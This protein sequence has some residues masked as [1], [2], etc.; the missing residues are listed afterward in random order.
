MS[1]SIRVTKGAAASLVLLLIVA[2][3]SPAHQ[4][5]TQAQQTIAAKP[6][7]W[8]EGGRFRKAFVIDDRL[9]ALRR[10]PALQSQVIRR[11]RL[12]RPVFIVGSSKPKTGQ[13]GFLRIAVTRRTRGWIHQSALAAPSRSGDDQRI[14]NLIESSSDAVDRITLCRII[15]D[16]FARSHLVPRALLLLGEEAERVAQTLSQRTRRRL[17][18]VRDADAS[19]HDYYLSD[20]GLDRYS[21]LGVA[22]DLD[23][24]TGE[25]IY[26]GKAYTDIVRRFPRS[27]EAGIARQHLDT[28][29]QKTAR[30]R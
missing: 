1:K 15:I 25:F 22:F 28:A 21:R 20:A 12:G 7:L 13:P 8:A 14:M 3:H 30:R 26:D 4:N 6:V 17:A 16:R 19:L 5:P 2:S 10:E 9:S 29:N 24:S 18:E 27:E 23:D 11:L